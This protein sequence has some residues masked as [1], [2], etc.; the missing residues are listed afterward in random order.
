VKVGLGTDVSGGH[1]SSI[2]QAIRD[3][4]TVSIASKSPISFREAFY[5]ATIGGSE[6]VGMKDRI[7]NFEVGKAFD[8]V[9]VDGAVQNSPFDIF[10]NETLIQRFEKF[11]FLG[12]DR[13]IVDV[14]VQGGSIRN[15]LN[16]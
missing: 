8:A 6:A 1:S 9:I 13:N 10:D 5:M 15:T 16:C 7:G 3:A 4:V 11:I 12:D 14:F 2:V